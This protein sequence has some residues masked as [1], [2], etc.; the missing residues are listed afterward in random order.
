MYSV[1]ICCYLQSLPWNRGTKKY[2]G[3]LFTRYLLIL[4]QM[5]IGFH[6]I[7]IVTFFLFFSA[8]IF[9]CTK[10]KSSWKISN[11]Y[12]KIKSYTY[13][14]SIL[15]VCSFENVLENI[16]SLFVVFVYYC[17]TQLFPFQLFW[18]P[19]TECTKKNHIYVCL[20]VPAFN[21]FYHIDVI[22]DLKQKMH[23]FRNRFNL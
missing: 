3:I 10:F 4:I 2:F 21:L 20:I 8:S 7:S 15:N 12:F 11:C 14:I 17:S 1:N 16:S 22:R 18:L 19:S 13:E 5:R 23:N 9:T 6:S